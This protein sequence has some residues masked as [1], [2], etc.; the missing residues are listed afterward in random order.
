MENWEDGIPPL[1]AK[2]Q[3]KSKW[4]DEDI[5][6][7][8]IKE[9]WE[10][11]DELASPSARKAWLQVLSMVYGFACVILKGAMIWHF[12]LYKRL[13]EEADY[14]SMI[15]L[16]S[17]KGDDKTLDNYIPKFESDFVE[18]AEHISHKLR[19]YKKSYHS[20]A[21]IKAVMRLSLTSLKAA[22]VKDI[23]S[24]VT[25]ILA[26]SVKYYFFL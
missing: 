25:V 19:P 15:E 5:D 22:D 23:A 12:A 8:D 16:F 24:L 20:I 9:S 6:D 10:D 1:L 18:Y 4:D 21:L 13:V 2:E 7:F 17:K 26:R 11:E 3:L 14:K